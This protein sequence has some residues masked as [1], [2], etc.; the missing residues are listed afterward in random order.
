MEGEHELGLQNGRP[1]MNQEAVCNT[2][3][4]QAFLQK[5]TQGAGS[6]ELQ[7]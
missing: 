6:M 1:N 2:T 4:I 7:I 3:C 5:K